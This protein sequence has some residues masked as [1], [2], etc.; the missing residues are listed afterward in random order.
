[1]KTLQLKGSLQILLFMALTAMNAQTINRSQPKPGPAPTINIGKPSRFV[2]DNGLKVLVVENHKLPQVTFNLTLDNLPVAEGDKTGL[3]DLISGMLGNGTT[4]TPKDKF[5]EEIDYLGAH[6]DFHSTGASGSCLSKYSQRILEL[7]A[8]GMLLPDFTPEEFEKEKA[9]TIEGLKA[10]EKNVKAIA[11]RV[12]NALVFGKNHPFGE[13]I[14]EQSLNA[15]TLNDVKNTHKSHFVPENA[16][17]VIIGDVDFIQIKKAVEKLFGQWKKASAPKQTY[18]NP[19]NVKASEINFVHVAH[20]VQSE[21]ALVNVVNLPMNSPDY[22][23][24]LLANQILGG[25]GEGR[26]FLNLR[27]KHG[28]TYG[29]YSSLKA[30]KYVSKFKSSSSV[31]NTVTDSAIVEVFNELKRIRT[32]KVS[33]EDLKNAKAK[34]IGNFVMQIEKPQTIARHALNIETQFLPENFYENFIK[35]IEAVTADQVLAVAN[36]YF[37]EANTRVLVIGK[38]EDVLTGLKKLNMPIRYFDA[39]GNE[40][41]E[42]K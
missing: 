39:F 40:H 23:P 3:D 9:K 11:E 16:Y 1:M 14:T 19:L 31:R 42:I 24:A 22:F 26:L 21:I 35:N 12:E 28:W 18:S 4:K 36:K 5:V 13:F 29:A 32:E 6:I 41:A 37:L 2:L 25:G 7:L 20:A 27:E 15:I 34:F 10:S 8:E 33:D 30:S 38:A 17:L